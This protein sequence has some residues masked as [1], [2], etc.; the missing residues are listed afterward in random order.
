[1]RAYVENSLD[2]F[3]P[4]GAPRGMATVVYFC[5][6][7][8]LSLLILP[9][10]VGCA[11]MAQR[12]DVTQ[13]PHERL[14]S[15]D[16]V[17]RNWESFLEQQ[18]TTREAQGFRRVDTFQG[19][20]DGQAQHAAVIWQRGWPP[21]EGPWG[22]EAV[23]EVYEL[24]VASDGHG[25]VQLLGKIDE[26][27]LRFAHLNGHDVN[28]DG[29]KELVAQTSTGG[30]CWAC[31][32]IRLFRVSQRQ[33]REIAIPTGE[34]I[35]PEALADLDGDGQFEVIAV[36]TQWEFYRELCHACSPRVRV[37]YAWHS[38]QY[39]EAS[40]RFPDYYGA[41]ITK[42]EQ[43]LQ[44]PFNEEYY[45]GDAVSL[46]L[47]YLQKGEAAYGW[48]QFQILIHPSRIKDPA[49]AE[50]AQEIALELRTRFQL[51]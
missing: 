20:L 12:P 38:G 23:L 36:D 9:V 7:L 6:L 37:I 29:L 40:H 48:Q 18:R 35:V 15:Q 13:K 50:K 1:M 39:S 42:L 25:L 11:I 4:H 27:I 26:D 41:Q 46:L 19:S 33:L 21:D 49:W 28:G 45:L 5:C 2:V 3:M 22:P 8:L 44:T 43:E 14:S 31:E 10:S 51:E 32:R 24:Q 16:R 47:N 30:N 17:V 34:S